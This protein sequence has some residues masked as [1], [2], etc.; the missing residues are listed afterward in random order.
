MIY[1]QPHEQT[2]GHRD[3]FFVEHEPQP[4]NAPK[5]D[6]S[7]QNRYAVASGPSKTRALETQLQTKLNIS[8]WSCG[9]DCSE[10]RGCSYESWRP[11]VGPIERI[12]HV[13]LKSKFESLIETK[14]LAHLEIPRL[15]VWSL[16][17]SRTAVA[18]TSGRRSS[19][20]SRINPSIRTGVR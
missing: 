10:S 17:D 13:S 3:P 14:L 11:E 5:F 1:Q 9:S 4:A 15:K 8:G 12:K 16:D 18:T 19:K 7:S 6:R 2:H 20:C